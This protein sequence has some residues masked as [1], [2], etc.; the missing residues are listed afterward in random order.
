[1]KKLKELQ[2]MKSMK[3]RLQ[4]KKFQLQIYVKLK[5]GMKP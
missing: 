5:I 2:S 4:V 3:K 1:M